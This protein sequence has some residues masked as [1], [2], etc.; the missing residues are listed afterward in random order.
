MVT[1]KYHQETVSCKEI[2]N[3]NQGMKKKCVQNEACAC[4]LIHVCP[5]LALPCMFPVLW[6]CS[7]WIQGHLS[8]SAAVQALTRP[9]LLRRAKYG[10]HFCKPKRAR[11]VEEAVI[12]WLE[13]MPPSIPSGPEHSGGREEERHRWVFLS[14][15]TLNKHETW[16]TKKHTIEKVFHNDRE[17]VLHI[18]C[19]FSPECLHIKVD[20]FVYVSLKKWNI[21]SV[22]YQTAALQHVPHFWCIFVLISC[23]ELISVHPVF[24]LFYFK[25]CFDCQY[26]IPNVPIM[27]ESFWATAVSGRFLSAFMPST[28]EGPT[29]CSFIS[30][31]SNRALEVPPKGLQPLL[32]S[33]ILNVNKLCDYFKHPKYRLQNYSGKHD[34]EI[35]RQKHRLLS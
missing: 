25:C 28:S 17:F 2:A 21:R 6:L 24:F 31:I 1:T 14:L 12:C 15:Q 23:W 5:A 3:L 33:F 29:G 35:C 4:G 32:N 18:L 13:I 11:C 8:F 7:T 34:C 16:D 20:I 10:Y 22:Q 30:S 26:K 27:P 9:F 19:H